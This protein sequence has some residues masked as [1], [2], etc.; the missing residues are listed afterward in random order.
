M[1][2]GVPAMSKCMNA[3]SSTTNFTLS[4]PGLPAGNHQ[5]KLPCNLLGVT[6]GAAADYFERKGV[7]GVVSINGQDLTQS[8]W[9]HAVGLRG[10]QLQVYLPSQSDVVQWN[11]DPTQPLIGVWLKILLPT[12]A[13]VG[14]FSTSSWQLDMS[15]MTKGH[16]YFNGFFVGP[17][18]NVMAQ[19]EGCDPCDNYTGSY[20]PGHCRYDCGIPSQSLY[21][22]PRDVVQPEGQINYIVIFE[23]QMGDVTG[24][25][26]NQ[27]N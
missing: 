27:R 23:E 15:S 1:A 7:L 12:P 25:K 22:V 6:N 2:P 11:Y 14:D 21:H 18:W 9:S 13:V 16:A 8:S 19:S 3:F 10:E 5:L 26:L 20:N 4:T 24:I 17:Y